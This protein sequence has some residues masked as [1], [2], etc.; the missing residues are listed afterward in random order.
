MLEQVQAVEEAR[1]LAAS[2]AHLLCDELRTGS[3]RHAQAVGC[4]AVWW[5][6][7][8]G[9]DARIRRV[10]LTAGKPFRTILPRAV[11]ELGRHPDLQY[12]L[13]RPGHFEGIS[14]PF[15]INL[16]YYVWLRDPGR[17]I[18]GPAADVVRFGAIQSE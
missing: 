3:S 12:H 10:A 7:A 6:V 8:A 4:C 2:A 16:D 13:N 1:A 11:Q 15:D 14:G 9:A 18:V 17:T 5:L